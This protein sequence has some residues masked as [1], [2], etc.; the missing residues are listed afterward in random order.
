MSQLTILSMISR[1]TVCSNVTRMPT[2]DTWGIFEVAR[3]DGQGAKRDAQIFI[4]HHRVT[5]VMARGISRV[6]HR[7][8]QGDEKD[9]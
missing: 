5:T 1:M 9:V 4:H 3:P 8:G 2:F 6:F 7:G